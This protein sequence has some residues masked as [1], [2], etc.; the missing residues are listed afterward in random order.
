MEQISVILK[1]ARNSAGLSVKEATAKLH[2]CGLDISPKTLYGWEGGYRQP[3]ADVFLILCKIYGIHSF[4]QISD[5]IT[6]KEKMS[7][8][9]TDIIKKYRLLD[10]RGKAA[11]QETVNREYSYVTSKTVDLSD[12]KKIDKTQTIRIASRN[13][14]S[15]LTLNEEQL[16]AARELLKKIEA[17]SSSDIDDD[18]I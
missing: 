2:E 1:N 4:R 6:P 3:D 14:P 9:E 17:N 5:E 11:V 8:D 7:S 15:T 13:G 10:E 18:L 12:A 16:K